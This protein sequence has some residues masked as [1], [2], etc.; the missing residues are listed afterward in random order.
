M[1]TLNWTIIDKFSG[2]KSH[3]LN[4]VWWATKKNRLHRATQ[5]KLKSIYD[6]NQNIICNC[7]NDAKMFVRY[8]SGSYTIVNHPVLGRHKDHCAYFTVVSGEIC[9]TEFG[10]EKDYREI[11]TFCAYQSLND[12]AQQIGKS[13]ECSE[14]S[15]GSDVKK[16]GEVKSKLYRLLSQLLFDSFQTIYTSPTGAR[17]M[18]NNSTS[19]SLA[20]F[21]RIRKAASKIS[22]GEKTLDSFIFYGEK[23]EHFAAQTLNKKIWD[24]AGRPHV[25]VIEIINKIEREN[26][27]ITFDDVNH[28]YKS[29]VIPGGNITSGP[30]IAISSMVCTDGEILR[31]STC[32]KQVVSE[33]IFMLVDSDLE[34]E[35]ALAMISRIENE[36]V[37]KSKQYW[38]LQKPVLPREGSNGEYLLPDFIITQKTNGKVTHKEIIEISLSELEYIDKSERLKPLLK[39]RFSCSALTQIKAY[40]PND[41]QQYI[42]NFNFK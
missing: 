30:F 39:E 34:R 33:N 12:N 8:Q 4:N 15:D 2:T 5:Y 32:I 37:N 26:L 25:F 28:T 9:H 21:A 7:G 27:D 24:G 38:T 6:A 23:G 17:R 13:N 41:I 11:L 3:Q 42:E 18:N 10:A 29:I 35:F 22:F 14:Y 20:H 1:A 40:I 16:G 19:R 36:T 31:H